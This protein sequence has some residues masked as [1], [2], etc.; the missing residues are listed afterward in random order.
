[1]VQLKSIDKQIIEKENEL[2]KLEQDLTAT[3]EELRS[4]G[5][6]WNRQ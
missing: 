3:Q 6:N 2:N 4:H 5:R 1:M